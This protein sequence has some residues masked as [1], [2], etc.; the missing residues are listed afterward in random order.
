MRITVLSWVISV[1]LLVGLLAWLGTDFIQ[2]GKAGTTNGEAAIGGHL[3]LI[4]GD[5]NKVTERDFA[6]RYMLVYFGYTHCP[7][8]CPTTLLMVG[9][10]MGRIG[11]KANKVTPVFITVDP[12]RDTAPVM[13]A[14]VKHFGTRMVGLTGTEEQVHQVA[15]SYKVYYSKIENENSALGYMVD[16]SS[17]I[18]LMGPNGKYI[19]HFPP[20]V[21][22]E[23]LAEGLNLHV[24]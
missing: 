18:Y 21:S 19:T 2:V 17:F 20:N 9:N 14:Y 5:G 1:L 8:I 10:A 13:G 7:N 12:A 4:N 11:A 22:E 6:G 15:A 3:D 23:A 16:H 24:E